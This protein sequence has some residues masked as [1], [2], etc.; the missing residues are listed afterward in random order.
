MNVDYVRPRSIL[1]NLNSSPEHK[2]EICCTLELALLRRHS[3]DF[4]QAY[5]DKASL[6]IAKHISK[7]LASFN[8]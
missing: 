7:N 4:N 1:G 3:R 2:V 6:N 5:N 8:Q